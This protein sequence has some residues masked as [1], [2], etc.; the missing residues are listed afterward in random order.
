MNELSK[1]ITDYYKDKDQDINDI[2]SDLDK[3]KIDIVRYFL[4]N[5]DDDKVYV[6][7]RSG[8]LE[9]YTRDK[10]VRSIKNAA[11]RNKQ[12]LNSSDVNIIMDDVEDSMKDLNRK[13][14]KTS[15]VKQF[16]KTALKEEGYS[17]IYDSYDLYIQG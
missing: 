13:V 8:N 7:K 3:A 16:V 10:I 5:S 6:I 12:Q 17:Q 9:E 14:F 15:E 4:E 1:L 11:D 2:L